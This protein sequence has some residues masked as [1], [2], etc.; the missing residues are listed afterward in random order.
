MVLLHVRSALGL[1]RPK[2]NMRV[3]GEHMTEQHKTTLQAY[4]LTV[5][6]DAEAEID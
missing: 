3:T 1:F 6:A 5:N 4:K 2:L